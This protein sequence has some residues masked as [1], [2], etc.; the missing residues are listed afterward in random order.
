MP[1][2]ILPPALDFKFK[3]D[4]KA[5][6]DKGVFSGYASVFGNEDSYGD[7]VQPGAFTRTIKNRIKAKG[8]PNFPILWN[9]NP[10]D[11]IGVTSAIAEDQK[12]L[13][14]TGELNLDVQR[15][16]EIYSLMK[17]GAI[18]GLSFGFTTIKDKLDA[19]GKRLLQELKLWEWSPV[20]FPANQMAGV[21]AV[22]SG[23]TQA[24]TLDLARLMSLAFSK[25]EWDLDE[26]KAWAEAR[27][28]KF[29]D[30]L[31]TEQSIRLS[32]KGIVDPK[33]E[34][35]NLSGALGVTACFKSADSGIVPASGLAIDPQLL[36]SLA[37]NIKSLTATYK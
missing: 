4:E 22:R 6:N 25:D 2:K 21:E 36:H 18:D 9:H 31:E 30:T 5:F 37:S 34:I 35:V 20:T 19:S 13:A 32:I 26:A 11:P 24:D 1:E 14:V 17:Q 29:T 10:S 23:Q 15:A 33:S 16:R 7:I 12:G 8:K 28:F 27:S 3:F